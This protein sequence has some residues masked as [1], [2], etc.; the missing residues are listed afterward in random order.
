MTRR[1]TRHVART[2][3]ARPAG[4]RSTL[5]ERMAYDRPA[6][7][8]TGSDGGSDRHIVASGSKPARRSRRAGKLNPP[9]RLQPGRNRHPLNRQRC[10]RARRGAPLG[11]REAQGSRP[12]ACEDT[13]AS[14]SSLPQLFER[15][16]RSERSEFCGRPGDR[17]SEGSRSEAKTAPVKRRGGLAGTF[18]KRAGDKQPWQARSRP[19][20][21]S[22]KAPAAESC[23]ASLKHALNS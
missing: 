12:R 19:P 11:R 13:R 18:A 3:G 21:Q 16:E 14:T 10:L 9:R 15:S 2:H 23:R 22:V 4:R 8:S 7:I 5:R 20:A 1:R 6:L 17:A